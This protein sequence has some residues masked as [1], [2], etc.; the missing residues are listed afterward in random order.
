MN[1]SKSQI[2]ALVSILAV[3]VIAVIFGLKKD[4]GGGEKVVAQELTMW[5]IENEDDISFSFASS[6]YTVKYKQFGSYASYEKALLDALASGTGPDIFMIPAGSLSSYKNKIAPFPDSLVSLQ[7][8]RQYFPQFAEDSFVDGSTVYALP[9]SIDTPALFYNRSLIDQAGVTLPSSWKTWNDM[10]SQLP[11]LI[12]LNP[13]GGISTPAIAL[14]GSESNIP[15]ASDIL[16]SLMLQ[17]GTKMTT[18]NG[19]PS[20]AS[21]EGENATAFYTRFAN[22]GDKYFTWD[23]TQENALDMFAEEK[24]PLVFGYHSSLSAIKEKNAY[25]SIEIVPMPQLSTSTK[26]AIIGKSYGF[27][28]SKQSPYQSQAWTYVTTLAGTDT[29]AEKYMTLSGNPPALRS[30]IQ[31]TTGEEF[32]PFTSQSL[33]AR[34]WSQGDPESVS[35]VFSQMIESIQSGK[36]D[37]RAALSE[38]QTEISRFNQ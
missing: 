24:L 28:V 23:T 6:I 7:G 16:Q 3:I 31:K 5:G 11:Q 35:N 37:V 20:F 1:F 36:L 26:R 2:I 22:Q 14:G 32:A 29:N 33:I 27:A 18:S 10:L 38:A 17:S 15:H 34:M 9:L 4:N 13:D 25:L 21:T 30:L 12:V 19:T 8:F